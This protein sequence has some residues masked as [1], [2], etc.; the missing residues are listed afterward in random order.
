MADNIDMGMSGDSDDTETLDQ[1]A[2]RMF[3]EV[4]EV[5][6]RNPTI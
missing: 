6:W 1:A 3:T 2:D 5:A 4:V